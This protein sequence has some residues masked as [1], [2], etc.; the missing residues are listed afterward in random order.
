[1][2][3]IVFSILLLGSFNCDVISTIVLQYTA[4]HTPL[5]NFEEAEQFPSLG[6]VTENGIEMS[7]HIGNKLSEMYLGKYGIPEKF[8]DYKFH[9][10]ATYAER[11]KITALATC[12]GLFPPGKGPKDPDNEEEFLFS[13]GVQPVPIDS[14]MKDNEYLFESD[15]RCSSSTRQIYR[16]LHSQSMNDYLDEH[17]DILKTFS[18]QLNCLNDP[19]TILGAFEALSVIKRLGKKLPNGM[20]DEQYNN[21]EAMYKHLKRSYHLVGD[22]D[23]CD[24]SIG[25]MIRQLA[26]LLQQ[27]SSDTSPAF[28]L[29]TTHSKLLINLLGCLANDPSSV[30]NENTVY[31]GWNA[32]VIIEVAD[33]AKNGEKANDG[34][35]FSIKY[36]L[37]PIMGKD[38]NLTRLHIKGCSAPSEESPFCPV[39]SFKSTF[40]H[41]LSDSS[42]F[43]VQRRASSVKANTS[44][45]DQLYLFNSFIESPSA[46]S[47]TSNLSDD[48]WFYNFCG[49]PVETVDVANPTVTLIMAIL[50]LLSLL[51]FVFVI[52]FCLRKRSKVKKYSASIKLSS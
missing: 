13:K 38:L 21:Y 47:G 49:F 9:F 50:C 34:N 43:N 44:D 4:E 46:S 24:A 37:N 41:L 16:S 33:Q 11:A 6:K 52:V 25:L 17:K 19:E 20:T 15:T 51:S 3:C 14:V 26:F 40:S 2:Q 10:Y 45:S 22:K 29:F 39:S 12:D 31:E 27:P 35:S 48:D 23:F 8:E 42:S 5:F 1:M 18:Q 7:K 32:V 36:D 28:T 30:V